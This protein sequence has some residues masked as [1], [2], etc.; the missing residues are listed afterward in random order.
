MN[1]F[2]FE[3]GTKAILGKGCVKEFLACFLNHYGDNVLLA[4]GSGSIKKNGIY[5]EIMGILKAGNK[6]VTEFGGIMPGPTYE[7]VMEGAELVKEN[8]TDMIL[9]VGGGSV[10]DC[11]K[12][13]RSS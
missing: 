1:N 13:L 6:T 3:N 11:C 5:D 10:M 9:A 12:A 7:K 4:Y 8:H 2:I